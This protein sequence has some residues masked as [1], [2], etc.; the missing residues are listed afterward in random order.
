MIAKATSYRLWYIKVWRDDENL[1][2]FTG[3]LTY[4]SD[5]DPFNSRSENVAYFENEGV[6]FYFLR[7]ELEAMAFNKGMKVAITE[8]GTTIIQKEIKG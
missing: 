7:T 3:P 1:L 5:R 4:T 2:N 8:N 6:A